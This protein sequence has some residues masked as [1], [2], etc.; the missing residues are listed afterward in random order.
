MLF[1]RQPSEDK[2]AAADDKSRRSRREAL[3]RWLVRHLG[4]GSRDDKVELRQFDRDHAVRLFGEV[5]TLAGPGTTHE[6][7]LAVDPEGADT[8]DMRR[9]SRRTV[10]RK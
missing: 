10:A 6:V 1:E 5:S 7:E 8:R 9:P 2:E 3:Q 4:R